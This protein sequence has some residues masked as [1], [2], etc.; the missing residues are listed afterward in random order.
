[1]KENGIPTKKLL[2]WLLH[3]AKNA[4]WQ[5][6]ANIV[7]GLIDVACKLLWVI[8][9]KHAIDI[10]TGETVGSLTMTGIFIGALM[11]I[12]IIARATSIWP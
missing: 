4:K 10:A 9:C 3:N 12:E 11:A 8:A 7:I 1:M 6:I 5:A 2:R